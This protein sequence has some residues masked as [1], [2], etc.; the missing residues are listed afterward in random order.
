M[1]LDP[2]FAGRHGVAEKLLC[3]TVG[4]LAVDQYLVNVIRKVVPYCAYD[5]AAV[6]VDLSGTLYFGSPLFDGFIQLCQVG[7]VFLQLL[8]GAANRFS[9]D[10]IAHPFR[11]IHVADNLFQFLAGSFLL[12]FAGDAG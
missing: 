5:Q 11:D 3:F 1:Q 12:Y 8:R 2:F 9:A 7:E 4:I 6:A 10:D